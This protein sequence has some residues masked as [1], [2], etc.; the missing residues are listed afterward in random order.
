MK[1]RLV[2]CLSLLVLLLA[3]CGK[4][5]ICSFCGEEKAGQTKMVLGE[6]VDICNDCV[7]Q[8]QTGN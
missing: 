6:E 4:K 8:L 3:G 1:K 5:V 2:L 7:E